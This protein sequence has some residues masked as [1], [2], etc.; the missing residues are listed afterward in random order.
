METFCLDILWC[1]QTFCYVFTY[2]DFPDRVWFSDEKTM[3]WSWV[4]TFK[5]DSLS[6]W[7]HK[8]RSGFHL[9]R[10]N[11]QVWG[12]WVCLH[13]CS[14]VVFFSVWLATWR[15][16]WEHSMARLFQLNLLDCWLC[17]GLP[18]WS[19]CKGVH[20]ECRRPGFAPWAGRTSVLKT[21]KLMAVL[22]FAW[23]VLPLY[24]CTLT[25][26]LA[27]LICSFCLS[28]TFIISSAPFPR[29]AIHV[30]GTLPPRK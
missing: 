28:G 4:I 30:A 20:L 11:A 3:R 26:K 15:I 21:G 18:E 14:S 5:L 6:Y 8:V 2:I 22:P 13:P 10:K 24:Q 27:S 17:C 7:I 25:G 19:S 29:Y 1:A 23:S 12:M 16:L 9:D